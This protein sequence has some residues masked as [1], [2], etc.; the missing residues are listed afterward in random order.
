[1]RP[2]TI[3]AALAALN[4]SARGSTKAEFPEPPAPLRITSAD[5]LAVPARRLAPLRIVENDPGNNDGERPRSATVPAW[6]Q[7]TRA[8]S[9]STGFAAAT[10]PA[11]KVAAPAAKFGVK[12]ASEAAAEVSYYSPPESA[13]S[14][15]SAGLTDARSFATLG[16]YGGSAGS[17]G[18]RRFLIVAVI[19]TALTAL[20]YFGYGKIKTSNVPAP[21]PPPVS[22]PQDSGKPDS[23]QP[24]PAL[25]PMSSPDPA[26]ET[27]T[28][29]RADSATQSSSPGT[30]AA[31]LPTRFLPANGNPP[32]IKIAIAPEAVEKKSDPTP[33]LVKSNR[34]GTLIHQSQEAA[35]PLSNH[36]SVGTANDAAL[37]G[38]LASAKSNLPAAAPAVARVSQGVSQGLLIKRVQPKYP[39]AALVAHVQGAVQIEATINKEGN[40]TNPRV[41]K[42]NPLFARAALDAVRQWRYKPYS[43]DGVPV[44]IQTE[45]T[46]NFKAN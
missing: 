24:A 46:V 41:L 4:A 20:G 6:P 42:G 35:P 29:D 16:K 30:V 28:P 17:G 36:L 1:M 44:E 40:V 18:T 25:A 26:P 15:S 31:S 27:A 23:G 8:A 33:L 38:L 37:S 13:P 9:T 39:P 19:V 21:V 45:I 5:E 32:V 2:D 7:T 3:P 34:V 11:K 14:P 12:V 10:A 22:T 43:L